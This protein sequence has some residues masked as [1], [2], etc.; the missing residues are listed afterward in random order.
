MIPQIKFSLVFD[1]QIDG[2]ELDEIFLKESMIL[3]SEASPEIKRVKD[4]EAE[5]GIPD[6]EV[7]GSENEEDEE[8]E[9]SEEDD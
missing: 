3:E 6:E 8:E 1:D 5:E 9:E 7:M 2:T 4:E